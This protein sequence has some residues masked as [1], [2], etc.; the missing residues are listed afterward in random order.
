MSH[1]PQP[2]L[3]LLAI[4]IKWRIYGDIPHMIK[5]RMLSEMLNAH[6]KLAI[7]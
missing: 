3:N 2:H 7:D 6:M 1:N 5:F 4:S